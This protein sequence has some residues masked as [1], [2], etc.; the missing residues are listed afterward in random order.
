[1]PDVVPPAGDLT[2]EAFDAR[3]RRTSGCVLG[4]RRL[5]DM[6]RVEQP[7]VHGGAQQG[8][9][10]GPVAGERRVLEG[11]EVVQTR[12]DEVGEGQ[13]GLERGRGEAARRIRPQQP[14]AALRLPAVEICPH[15]LVDLVFDRPPRLG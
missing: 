8:M 7:E 14:D 12:L 6:P 11:A 2:H 3:Y 10:H 13:L 4:G 1:M 5:D 9:C 15:F